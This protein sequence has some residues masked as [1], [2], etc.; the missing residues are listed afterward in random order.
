MIPGQTLRVCPERIMISFLVVFLEKH[1]QNLQFA[2]Y[3]VKRESLE[4]T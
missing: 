2:E 3:Q 1:R 4:K